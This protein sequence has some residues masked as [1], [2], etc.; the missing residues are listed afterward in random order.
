MFICVCA[1]LSCKNL[2]STEDLLN[3]RFPFA[4]QVLPREFKVL[5]GDAVH[6]RA[7]GG[8]PPYE[9]K[10]F[11]GVGS[12][13]R[14]GAFSSGVPGLTVIQVNDKAGASRVV[15]GVV[16]IV[17]RD[18]ADLTAVQSN[19]K[20]WLKA[21]SLSLNDGNPVATWVNSAVP[22]VNNAVSTP[23]N[24]PILKTKIYNGKP[25]LRF[26][27]PRSLSLGSLAI[28]G[29]F[30]VFIVA[31]PSSAVNAFILRGSNVHGVPAFGS[32]YNQRPYEYAFTDGGPFDR[33]LIQAHTSG[34]NLFTYSQASDLKVRTFF[35]G[36][37]QQD[38]YASISVAAY[39]F[40][41]I[42]GPPAYPP[43]ENYFDGDIAEIIF[44][45]I[46]LTTLDRYAIDC[47]LM[48]K[49]GIENDVCL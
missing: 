17:S 6:L 41:S 26:S 15:Q 46:V 4:L 48:Q 29:A 9:Y 7:S 2:T 49:Y 20:L 12:V 36:D 40:I 10:I 33:F 14:D 18:P 27:S 16:Q 21:D 19:L 37:L 30:T 43:S 28:G 11:S 1:F 3:T 25:T 47:H 42:G 39:N 34:L 45:S 35:N 38:T 8:T 23:G 32:N 31:T 22:G 44:Y 24:E 5:A 13:S